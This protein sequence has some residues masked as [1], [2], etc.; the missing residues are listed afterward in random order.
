MVPEVVPEVVDV[1]PEVVPEE[2]EVFSE[3]VPEVVAVS[4]LGQQP[5]AF[6]LVAVYVVVV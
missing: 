2:E 5:D 4:V 3:V 1:V 6:Q